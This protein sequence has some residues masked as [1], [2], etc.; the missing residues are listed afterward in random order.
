MATCYVN[1]LG[2]INAI[3]KH[4][5][6]G[7]LIQLQESYTTALQPNYKDLIAPALLR[8]MG[9]GV[10]MAIYASQKALNEAN[11]EVPDAIITATGLGCIEDSEKFLKSVLEN[12]E[13][14]L[15]PT[16]FIQS[17]HNTFGG[18]IALRL[19][20]K[21]YNFTYVNEN[22]GFEMALLDGFVQIKSDEE[23]SVLVGGI[24]EMAPGFLELFKLNGT[25]YSQENTLAPKWSEGAHF[26]VLSPQKSHTSYAEV[27]DVDL[28]LNPENLTLFISDFLNRNAIEIT[29]IDALVLGY[30]P[31]EDAHEILN[32]FNHSSIITYKSYLGQYQT[33]SAFGFNLACTLLKNQEIEEDFYLIKKDRRVKHICIINQNKG[34]DFSVILLKNV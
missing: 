22:S 9:K 2:A 7:K 18:Q 19:Q 25:I 24:E 26:C 11:V 13:E 17:T 10:K 4:E 1:G 6:T 16:S 30:T 29:A 3:Q 5:I 32:M 14:F 8:R 12:Q 23:N 31:N 20:A 27:L 21:G 34:K 15:T 33:A 28:A